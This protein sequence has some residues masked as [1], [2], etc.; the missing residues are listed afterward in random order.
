MKGIIVK[1]IGG[2]Y[3]VKFNDSIIKC[4]ARGKFR[5]D[6]I[7][8][9]VGDKV[10]FS[11]KNNQGIIEKI[12]ER[13]NELIRPS[14]A[15]VT[16]AFIVTTIKEPQLNFNLLNKFLILCEAK[17]LK[18]IVCVNKM[19]I[20]DKSD[21]QLLKLL[22]NL[23]ICK[24]ETVLVSAK[25]EKN[26]GKLRNKLKGE[27][28]VFCGASGVGKST[29]FNKIVGKN[30]MDTGEISTK[31]KRGKNTTRHCEIIE[32]NG[33]FIVDTPGFSE[34]DTSFLR[35]E[36]LPE[37]FP[38]FRKFIGQCR[39]SNCI[40]D[41]E[42]GCAIKENVEKENI[43]RDRYNFYIYLLHELLKNKRMKGEYK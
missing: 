18:P 22:K 9:I 30:I 28:T 24:Y 40:H 41:K 6:S 1:G 43:T 7:K 27:V 8:P 5:Y 34:I 37:Y 42:I 39:F 15:N 26:I 3:H 11:I 36:E 32:Y 31:L 10:E 21:E 17:N 4:K 13:K 25:Y 14:V 16:Q 33:G 2:L 20:I 12:F 23:T 35:K 19:D 29:L 38:E